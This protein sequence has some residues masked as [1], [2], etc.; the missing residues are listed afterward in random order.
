MSQADAFKNLAKAARKNQANPVES[1][2]IAPLSLPTPAL[3]PNDKRG[4]G[5]PATGK[6]SD[7]EWIGR[8]FYVKRETDLD[9]EDELLKLKRQEVNQD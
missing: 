2:A 1:E 6:R 9:V 5:R 7:E 4:R 8:T 3:A